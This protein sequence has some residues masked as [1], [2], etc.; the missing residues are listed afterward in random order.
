MIRTFDLSYT[1]AGRSSPALDHVDVHFRRGELALLAGASGSGKSTLA[2][3]ING[4]IPRSAA[5]GAL[6]GRVEIDGA[7]A[8]SLSLAAL[9]QRIGTVLQDPEKQI[10]AA[11]VLGEIAFGPENLG[12]PRDEILRRVHTAADQLGIRR[13]LGRSTV[14]L[15]GGE[16]QRVALAGI[17]AMQPAALLLDEPLASLDPDAA[18]S[19]MALLR[20]L[21]DAGTAV[22]V[23]EHRLSTVRNAQPE[24]VVHLHDGRVVA[25]PPESPPPPP[26]RPRRTPGAPIVELRGVRF[27]YGPQQ[28]VLAGVD[29]TIR[30]GERIALL[31]ANGSGKSTLCRHLIGL[32]RPHSGQIRIDGRDAGT[33]TVAEIAR[34]VGYV[35][36]SPGAMLFARTLREELAF[37]PRNLGYPPARVDQLVARAADAMG[38]SDRLGES[39]FALSFG[40]QK[41]ASVAAALAMG[42]RLL[43]LDEPTA[44]QDPA[45]VQRLMRAIDAAESV[46]A[47][48]FTTHDIDFAYTWADRVLILREGLLSAHSSPPAR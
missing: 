40:G 37:G 39:P 44:G 9:G 46:E 19:V 14:A 17:L 23:V 41:R 3:C 22:V 12:L 36:Q 16:K 11:D 5:G 48:L 31:G 26:T 38:L 28:P 29:L 13:L 18:R 1:Y 20:S 30:T 27:G 25:A 33:L 6:S 2:R 10:V 8:A 15:S 35:F 42:T 43:V 47:V 7:D 45:S 32:L 4:L 21:A 34:T 24:Q